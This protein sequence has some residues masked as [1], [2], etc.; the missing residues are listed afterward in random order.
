MQKLHTILINGSKICYKTVG[1]GT[2]ILFIHGWGVDHLLWENQIEHTVRK[3]RNNYQRIYFDLPG[4][5]NS[6]AGNNI[7]NSD[8]ILNSINQFINSVIGD[9]HFLVAGESYGGYLARGLLLQRSEEIDG[10]FLLCPLMY[11]GYR[12]GR[13]SE[14]IILERDKDFIETLPEKNREAFESL[15]V[16]QTEQ[17][18]KDYHK[19]INTRIIKENEGFL[20]KKLDGAFSHDINKV[21][22]IYRKPTLILLGRQDTEVGFEDQYELFRNFPRAT[23]AVLDK[24]GHCLQIEQKKIFK[25]VLLEWLDRVRSYKKC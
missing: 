19:D 12:T 5:G 3:I 4:M 22:Y 11:P 24:S 16:V 13:H 7:H 25:A 14:H 2:P 18:Y 23:L 17:T 21:P 1:K 10:L 6:T 8:D 15:S 9:K 20:A